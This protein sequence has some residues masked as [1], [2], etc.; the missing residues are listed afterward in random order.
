MCR[1]C[2]GNHDEKTLTQIKTV[3]QHP[4]A[5]RAALMADGHLGYGMPIGGVVAYD[6]AVSPEGVGF[7]IGCGNK[8][9][10]TDRKFEDWNNDVGLEVAMDEIFDKVAFGV[11]QASGINADHPLFDDPRFEM[12]LAK[13]LKEIARSQLG[14][15]G[16][17]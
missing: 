17:G 3:A 7:D 9:V 11:G 1:S 15:V 6:N 8:A 14:S 10:K 2:S 16:S 12:E 13:P 5:V 4:K